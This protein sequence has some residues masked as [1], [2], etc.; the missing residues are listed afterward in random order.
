ML[1]G[2]TKAGVKHIVCVMWTHPWEDLLSPPETSEGL[3]HDLA[4]KYDRCVL[5]K[6]LPEV[7]VWL[8]VVL[9]RVCLPVCCCLLG[10]LCMRA[11]LLR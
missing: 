4:E 2:E 7:P 9:S 1:R 3:Q 10:P 8:A 11:L 5:W 6:G